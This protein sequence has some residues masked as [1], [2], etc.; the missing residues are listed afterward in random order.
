MPP[1]PRYQQA[2]EAPVRSGISAG[3]EREAGCDPRW[4]PT[5]RS[6]YA[7]YAPVEGWSDTTK[8]VRRSAGLPW[9]RTPESKSGSLEGFLGSDLTDDGKAMGVVPLD[10]LPVTREADDTQLRTGGST[11]YKAGYLPYSIVDG[12][13]QIRKDFAYWRAAVKGAETASSPEERAWFEA[14]RRLREKLTLR[15][16]GVWSHYVADA[17]QPMHVSVHFNGWGD[18]PN[19]IGFTNSKKI[20]AYFEGEFVKKNLKRDAVAAQVGA[21]REL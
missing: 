5:Q 4:Y 1:W 13:Q 21:I 19:P 12:W 9:K 14:D 3:P 10:K 20:H 16:I 15:D 17:S 11:Q 7:D 8:I 6:S 18:Y 2:E